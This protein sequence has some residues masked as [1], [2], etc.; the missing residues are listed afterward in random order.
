MHSQPECEHGYRV[1][2]CGDALTHGP[3][4]WGRVSGIGAVHCPGKANYDMTC[5]NPNRH[6][7]HLWGHES[8]ALGGPWNCRGVGPEAE[9]EKVPLDAFESAVL[10]DGDTLLLVAE[11]ATPDHVK[12]TRE[13]LEHVL[14]GIRVVIVAGYRQALVHVRDEFRE[15]GKGG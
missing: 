3:H 15:E 12:R 2:H 7:P 8:D 1:R 4:D 9:P 11:H 6:G 13:Y 10:R 14:P 5:S